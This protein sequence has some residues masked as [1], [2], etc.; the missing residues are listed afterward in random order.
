[1]VKKQ[2]VTFVALVVILSSSMML[3]ACDNNTHTASHQA[4]EVGVVTLKSTSLT[5]TTDLPGRTSPFRIAEIRPQVSG[6]ILKRNFTEG[7]EIKAGE[8]LYQ[9]DPA[10][11]KADYDKAKGDLAQAQANA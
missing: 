2:R 10:T 9:I 6:I 3:A 5:I 4:P 1:M 7:S 11:Y 8:S